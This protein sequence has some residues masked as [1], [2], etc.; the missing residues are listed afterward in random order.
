MRDNIV[1]K[2]GSGDSVNFKGLFIE[3]LFTVQ[4]MAKFGLR[5]PGIIRVPPYRIERELP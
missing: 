5:Q 3:G 2:H 4:L 1:Y